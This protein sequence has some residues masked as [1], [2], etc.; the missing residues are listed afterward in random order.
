MVFPNK[1]FSFSPGIHQQ[2]LRWFN[3]SNNLTN[4]IDNVLITV[5]E[6]LA[7]VIGPSKFVER[8]DEAECI[9]YDSDVDYK[10]LQFEPWNIENALGPKTWIANVLSNNR[11]VVLKLWDAWKFDPGSWNRES[12]I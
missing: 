12:D 2:Q 5:T 1:L 4:P 11:K 9:Q 6:T 8:Y 7:K 3:S 10:F